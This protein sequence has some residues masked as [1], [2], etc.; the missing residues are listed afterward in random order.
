MPQAA[1]LALLIAVLFTLA[2]C[3]SKIR[4]DFSA[5][6]VESDV[7]ILQD[8]PAVEL[9][10]WEGAIVYDLRDYDAWAQ[11]HIPGARRVT[12]ADLK[13]G[14]GLPDD[15]AAPVLFMGDGP[16]DRRPEIAA[17]STLELGY[18]DVQIFPGGWRMWIGAH[19]IRDE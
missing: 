1:R 3:S 16:L 4:R 5:G 8:P 19:P 17:Q 13:E 2:A 12:V 10:V 14:R 9:S 15:K 11:G 18:T 6:G 7:I